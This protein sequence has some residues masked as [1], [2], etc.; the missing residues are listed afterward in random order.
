MKK[1]LSGLV[2]FTIIMLTAS[3]C[4][5][6]ATVDGGS[7]TFNGQTYKVTSGIADVTQNPTTFQRTGLPDTT[8]PI[9]LSLATVCSTNSAYG[10]IVFTFYTYPKV[11]GAYAIT[12]NALP[13]SGSQE[14]AVNMIL[15]TG[16]NYNGKIYNPT[17]YSASVSTANVTVGSNGWI[18][19]SIPSLEMARDTVPSDSAVLTASV[20]QTQAPL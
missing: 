8:Y 17:P 20:K 3:S 7:W 1:I 2:A 6:A 12:P 5:K 11:S 15:S 19:I 14:V 9:N 4:K 13:D 10:D 16:S 18:T